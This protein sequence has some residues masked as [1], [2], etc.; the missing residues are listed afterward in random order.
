MARVELSRVA[1]KPLVEVAPSSGRVVQGSAL[2][3]EIEKRRA[4]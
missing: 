1:S 3:F 2:D 4:A